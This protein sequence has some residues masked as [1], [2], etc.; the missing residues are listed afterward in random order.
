M[1]WSQIEDISK[2]TNSLLAQLL[3]HFGY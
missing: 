2:F 1:L 3:F